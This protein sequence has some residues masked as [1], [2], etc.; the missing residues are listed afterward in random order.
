VTELQAKRTNRALLFGGS[1]AA[2]ALLAALLAY[3]FTV[4]TDRSSALW[5]IAGA[6]VTG[7]AALLLKRWAVARSLGAV[8]GAAG[9]IFGVRLVLL[10]AGIAVASSKHMGV[11]A[12]A[13]GFFAVYFVLQWLEIGYVSLE[14]KHST[15]GRRAFHA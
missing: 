8:L 13:A 14:M 3:A 7:V 5:G 1:M 2:V 15:S 10:G 9:A 6:L 12:F 4:G 11:L